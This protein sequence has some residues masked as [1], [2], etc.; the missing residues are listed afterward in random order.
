V[1]F[2]AE[3][4]NNALEG[5]FVNFGRL[6]AMLVNHC[7]NSLKRAGMLP[8]SYTSLLPRNDVLS[9][10][11]LAGHLFKLA[12]RSRRHEAGKARA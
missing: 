3:S 9:R 10:P 8:C 12:P 2:E 6:L 5:I 7:F 4:K 1:I 11:T